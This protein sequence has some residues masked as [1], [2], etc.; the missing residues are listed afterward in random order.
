MNK[1]IIKEIAFDMHHTTLAYHVN[2]PFKNEKGIRV[3]SIYE[4][5]VGALFFMLEL[6][7]STN[8]EMVWNDIINELGK[9][10]QYA[11][12]QVTNNYTLFKG[13]LGIGFFYL[14]VF[15]LTSKA[16][17][18]DKATA[19]ADEY[20]KS[21]SY[22][23]G[24]IIKP[25]LFDGISGV[26]LFSYE[27]YQFTGHLWLLEH[28]EKYT[29]KLL[30]T[31][32]QDPSGV[33][34]GG[35]TNQSGKN[36]GYAAGTTGIAFVLN[37][38]GDGFENSFLKEIAKEAIAYEVNCLAKKKHKEP[39]ESKYSIG[40]GSTGTNM[41]QLY[42]AEYTNDNL[43][44]YLQEFDNL[45]HKWFAN[46]KD[47]TSWGLFSGISGIGAAFNEVGQ[48]TGNIEFVERAQQLAEK[49]TAVYKRQK[50]E[51]SW[52]LEGALG[53]GYF[54]LKLDELGDQK[55]ELFFMPKSKFKID[56]PQLPETSVFQPANKELLETFIRSAYEQT[57]KV[58]RLHMPLAYQNFIASSAKAD[59]SAFALFIKQEIDKQDSSAEIDTIRYN[60]E[61]E[62]FIIATIQQMG[63]KDAYDANEILE[64]DRIMNLNR[65][66]FKELKLVWSKKARIFSNETIDMEKVKFNQESFI[67]F[68]QNYGVESHFYMVSS[69]DNLHCGPFGMLKFIYDRFDQ[70]VR[71]YE[72]CDQIALF[73]CSQDDNVLELIK[74]NLQA[75]DELQ[76]KAAINEF[77]IEGVK[78]CFAEGLL[79]NL[80][81]TAWEN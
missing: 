4:G 41:V 76:L 8:D 45:Q 39:D 29:L 64:I 62:K 55:S 35:V 37:R 66:A 71:I 19:L 63:E 56:L 48:I 38:I 47:T 7:R 23:N 5:R 65:P 18:L 9:I 27:L 53:I 70:P 79:E 30:Y 72:V 68:M 11:A 42:G 22:L 52:T 46:I 3:D 26:L 14:K 61:K 67:N 77:V 80:K 74:A 75:K 15:E 2:T 49:L 69:T 78:F 40:Y 28:I 51:L 6:F 58:A 20:Y 50:N 44:K 25:A 73:L 16:E 24:I 54:L 12:K 33:F 60:F 36:N 13:R 57:V 17:F 32:H 59:L 10:E 34:W 43:V 1:S 21:N 31:C 81:T